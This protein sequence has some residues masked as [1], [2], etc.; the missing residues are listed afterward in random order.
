M[1]YAIAMGQIIK[2]TLIYNLTLI[3]FHSSLFADNVVFK[4]H[5][6][7]D[8]TVIMPTLGECVGLT[9]RNCLGKNMLWLC[10]HCG[11]FF[12]AL[13]AMKT[14][15]SDEK[16]DRPS[17]KRVDCDETEARFVIPD[18]RSSSLVF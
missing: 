8:L 7:T 17:V 14:R 10:G 2:R 5:H 4:T 9:H 15:S 12:T 11:I 6:N 13:H 3:I 18:E 1:L 16:T